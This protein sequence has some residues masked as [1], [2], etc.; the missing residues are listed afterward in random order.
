LFYRQPLH[1][2]AAPGSVSKRRRSQQLWRGLAQGRQRPAGFNGNVDALTIGVQGNNTTFDF[3]PET[4]C[5]GV[6]YVNGAAGDDAFGGDSPASAK[7][8]I[9]AAVN[10]VDSGGSVL[11][12]AGSYPE[13]VTIT[14]TLS[15]TGTAG[16]AGPTILAPATLPP[17]SNPDSAIVKISG[18]GVNA[19]LTGFTVMG[20]GPAGCGSILAGI[21]VRDDAYAHIHHNRIL[22]I[23]DNPLSGCQNGIGILIGRTALSSSGAATLN[24]NL[25][26][27]YQKAGIVVSYGSSSAAITG[28]TVRGIGPTS[29]I[30]QNGIQVSSGATAAISGN[31]IDAHSYTP[32]SYISTGVL[33]YGADA[34]TTGNTISEAQVGIYHLDGSGIHNANIISATTAGTGSPGFWGIIVDAPPPGRQPAP[35]A[36]S[37]APAAAFSAGPA[38]ALSPTAL[39][40]VVVANNTL[41]GDGTTA[42]VGL[43]A[44]AGFGAMDIDLAATHNFI[45]N[46]GAGVVILECAGSCSSSVF[47]RVDLNLNSIS[48][49][50]AGLDNSS[51]FPVN[52]EANWWGDAAGPSGAGAGAGDSVSAAVDF[53]PWLCQGVD[54]DPAPGFQ[55]DPS[56]C[57]NEQGPGSL[58]YYLPILSK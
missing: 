37:L 54:A 40:T 32:F 11:V 21:F 42:G 46:W 55:P 6:C 24:D 18:A 22:D 52:G 43:E 5:A 38:A 3:E 20:P 35:F 19:E 47:T 1:L 8:T 10:Q 50:L 4:P 9:Q 53:D 36:E 14:K 56:L 48:G 58:N 26:A 12:A 45:Q 7:K 15:L 25:V 28:N 30:A 41:T 39:Q 29:L 49:N 16:A 23:R 57:N 51:A 13:Q 34:D 27:G 44:D 33:L 2:G 17:A 31:T